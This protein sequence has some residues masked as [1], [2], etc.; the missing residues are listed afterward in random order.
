MLYSYYSRKAFGLTDPPPPGLNL[1]Q[2]GTILCEVLSLNQGWTEFPKSYAP[3][4]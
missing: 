1:P 3:E 2:G 4:L